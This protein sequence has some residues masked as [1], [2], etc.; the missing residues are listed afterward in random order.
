MKENNTERSKKQDW[1]NP[2]EWRKMHL[3]LKGNHAT[4]KSSKLIN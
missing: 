2:N 4:I 3:N 1:M